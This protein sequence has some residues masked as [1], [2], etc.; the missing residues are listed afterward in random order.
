MRLWQLSAPRR[1]FGFVCPKKMSHTQAYPSHTNTCTQI[2]THVAIRRT[3]RLRAHTLPH[4]KNGVAWFRT[5]TARSNG[6]PGLRGSENILTS[7]LE[8]MAWPSTRAVASCLQHCQCNNKRHSCH[9]LVII[10][11]QGCGET[12]TCVHRSSAPSEDN[13]K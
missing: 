8:M 13:S 2:Q 1:R 7:D 5:K 9:H 6:H 11:L 4:R 12:C 3:T 10:W